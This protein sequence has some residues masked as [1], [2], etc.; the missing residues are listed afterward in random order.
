MVGNFADVTQPDKVNNLRTLFCFCRTEFPDRHFNILGLLKETSFPVKFILTYIT[1][2]CEN[3]L[4]RGSGDRDLEVDEVPCYCHIIPKGK[5]QSEIL[6][7]PS[8]SILLRQQE[9][10]SRASAAERGRPGF[11]SISNCHSQRDLNQ[12]ALSL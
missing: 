1:H 4:S 6:F 3:N 9:V 7:C 10:W 8:G 5:T 11:N 2:T 12:V